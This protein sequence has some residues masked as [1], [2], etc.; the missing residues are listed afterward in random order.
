[1]SDKNLATPERVA[2]KE[3]F[4][5]M[6]KE[7]GMTQAQFAKM[8][9]L[10]P[11]LVSKAVRP[12]TP[13]SRRVN[14]RKVV[15]EAV[16]VWRAERVRDCE[17]DRRPA[18]PDLGELPT[19]RLVADP[20]Q[21][22]VAVYA[23][24]HPMHVRDHIRASMQLPKPK[25]KTAVAFA[26]MTE[27]IGGPD[28]A[29]GLA[30]LACA[31]L[32]FDRLVNFMDDDGEALSHAVAEVMGGTGAGDESL[33]CD[34]GVLGE[35]I[36]IDPPEEGG[37]KV[38]GVRS[39]PDGP[40]DAGFVV[41]LR[42]VVKPNDVGALQLMRLTHEVKS[43]ISERMESWVEQRFDM[44]QLENGNR[45]AVFLRDSPD[46][47]GVGKHQTFDNQVGA[48]ERMYE[49]IVKHLSQERMREFTSIHALIL[50][51]NRVSLCEQTQQRCDLFAAHL[52]G[53]GLANLVTTEVL[54]AGRG[55]ENLAGRTKALLKLIT[56]S[57]RTLFLVIQDECHWGAGLMK[58]KGSKK[59]SDGAGSSSGKQTQASVISSILLHK[60]FL[61]AV[62]DTQNVMVVQVSATPHNQL[63]PHCTMRDHVV[64]MLANGGRPPSYNGL[65]ELVF[66]ERW[67]ADESLEDL[68]DADDDE[69]RSLAAIFFHARTSV[70]TRIYVDL[71]QLLW[72]ARAIERKDRHPLVA[73]LLEGKQVVHAVRLSSSKS[74]ALF[75]R[76]IGSLMAVDAPEVAV[77]YSRSGTGFETVSARFAESNETQFSRLGA[78]PTLLVLVDKGRMGDSFPPNFAAFDLRG[79]Y[80]SVVSQWASFD[81]DV[82]RAFGHNTI[83]EVH[84]SQAAR[85]LAEFVA[86]TKF[87]DPSCDYVAAA[88]R[89]EL[90]KTVGQHVE[91]GDDDGDDEETAGELENAAEEA[92][93]IGFLSVEHVLSATHALAMYKDQDKHYRQIRKSIS[94]RIVLTAEPQCGKTGTFLHLIELCARAIPN[95]RVTPLMAAINKLS[96]AERAELDKFL[97]NS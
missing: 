68:L 19:H 48:A 65:D 27:P 90:I 66:K 72:Y 31:E 17:D 83:C 3:D 34:G 60:T 62:V 10:D 76:A 78:C 88:A 11:S 77:V 46:T 14:A 94:A 67:H 33:V 87:N 36:S 84:S 40:V 95:D 21:M 22:L 52:E 35:A 30:R 16:N 56:K 69:L 64:D 79:R 20:S 75:A 59:E 50:T 29:Q 38:V 80:R 24:G 81:Q 32:D 18:P 8:H 92:N 6:L 51:P 49:V 12:K 26:A 47:D 25:T 82:G 43:V 23:A 63:I 5:A 93:E 54:Q 41:L 73:P 13:E 57:P 28:V 91:A 71:V 55:A 86:N 70:S 9:G 42:K 7:K 74:L 1:M 45:D 39:R 97:N 53:L 61:E 37:F 2:L 15:R 85:N 96:L 58:Q 44:S 89:E 4:K